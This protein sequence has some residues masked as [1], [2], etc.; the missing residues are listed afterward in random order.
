TGLTIK[1]TGLSD[2][3]IAG[4]AH[5][6][7]VSLTQNCCPTNCCESCVPPY[8]DSYT[9]VLQPGIFY[10]LDNPFCHGTANSLRDLIP[11]APNLTRLYIWNPNAGYTS[12]TYFAS[13]WSW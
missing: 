1:F 13:S 9:I 12:Y 4:G 11:I 10:Y 2:P 5:I 6:D 8:P 3:N 7:H